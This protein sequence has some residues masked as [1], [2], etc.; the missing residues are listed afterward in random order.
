MVALV[1]QMLDLNSKL[2][3]ARSGQREDDAVLAG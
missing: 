3:D 2:Q 1:T